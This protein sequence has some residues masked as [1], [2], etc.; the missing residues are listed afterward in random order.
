MLDRFDVDAFEERAAIME[1]DAGMSRFEA[2]AKAA[3]AQG[4]ARWQA[5]KIVKEA[6]NANGS[7]HTGG[8]RDTDAEMAGEQR[9]DDLPRM[10]RQPQKENRPMPERDPNAGRRGLVLPALRSQGRGVL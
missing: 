6:S 1:F 4:V 9:A 10:Q 8:S 2:E 5:L 7:R 3:E